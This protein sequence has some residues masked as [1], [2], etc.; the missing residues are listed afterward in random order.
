M[1][2]AG[3][4]KERIDRVKKKLAE[5]KGEPARLRKLRKTLKRAQRVRRRLLQA[6]ARAKAKSTV[7]S[8]EE[9]KPEGAPAS[10]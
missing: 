7:K 2:K 4:L 1:P 8:G 10:A 5:G 6:D 9:K 3:T